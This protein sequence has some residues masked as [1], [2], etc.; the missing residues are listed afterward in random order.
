[1]RD[2]QDAAV[3]REN[4]LYAASK[5]SPSTIEALNETVESV[6]LQALHESDF[7]QHLAPRQLSSSAP[8]LLASF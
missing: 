3:G 7:T 1:M 5:L 2:S 6:W 8:S 4:P